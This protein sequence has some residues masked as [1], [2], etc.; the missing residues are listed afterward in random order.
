MRRW[1]LM[2]FSCL[3][4]VYA[5]LGVGPLVTLYE[6]STLPRPLTGFDAP[7]GGL[8]WLPL[9]LRHWPLPPT[10]TPS[11]TPTPIPTPF[12]SANVRVNDDHTDRSQIQ[13]AVAMDAVGKAYAAWVDGR[14]GLGLTDIY[15]ALRA[16][17]WDAWGANRRVTGNAARWV[18]EPTVAVD[19]NGRIHVA[20]VDRRHGS[21][22]TSDIYW[23]MSTD[24]GITWSRNEPIHGDLGT[25]SR[26]EPVLL[27]DAL[28]NVHAVWAD[29]RNGDYDIYHARL[30]A[31]ST[32]WSADQRVNDDPA[33]A[34]QMSPALALAS[35]GDLY[36]VWYDARSDA[37]WN[38]D[39]YWAVL[40]AGEMTWG[41]NRPVGGS[42]ATQSGPSLAFSANGDLHAV[43]KALGADYCDHIFYARL[44]AGSTTWVDAGIVNENVGHCTVNADAAIGVDGTGNI[45]VVW[46]NREPGLVIDWDLYFTWRPAGATAWRA[47]AR[48]DDGDEGS[49]TEVAIAGAGGELTAVWRDDRDPRWGDDIYAAR[50][51]GP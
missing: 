31:G 32:T 7:D 10:P 46:Q 26:K 21:F 40:P 50:I 35:N 12:I 43:W 15:F 6:A 42:T 23:S 33:G 36:A 25:T 16:A 3:L 22:T 49:A 1:L 20:W 28:G 18:S 11:P 19:T 8:R 48:L 37:T 41:V 17:G 34:V 29:Q 39:L 51:R 14:A 24:G 2:T 30:E 4:L 9:I 38:P 13:P 5:A 45:F 47:V 44:P 27:A